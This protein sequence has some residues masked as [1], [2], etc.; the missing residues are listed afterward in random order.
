MANQAVSL[1]DLL[2]DVVNELYEAEQRRKEEHREGR[3]ALGTV[4]LELKVTTSKQG[5]GGLRFQIV[6]ADFGG[7]REAVSTIKLTLSPVA[8]GDVDQ[9]GILFSR[10]VRP[11][12][13]E[14]A[15]G[16]W[17][18]S[19]QRESLRG[20]LQNIIDG[21]EASPGSDDPAVSQLV[22]RLTELTRKLDDDVKSEPD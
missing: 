17:W 20:E 12:D 18:S 1:V 5:S 3:L 13:S 14:G 9:Y 4:E 8:P 10:G 2:T 15:Q 7:K 22:G 21:A 19:V 16:I 6:G 11:D